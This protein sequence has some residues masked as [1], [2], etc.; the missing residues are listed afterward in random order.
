MTEEPWDSIAGALSAR[1][2]RPFEPSSVRA[3]GG[4]CI[5]EA[6]VLSDGAWQVFVKTNAASQFSMFEAEM[7]GLEL[8]ANANVIHVPEIYGGGVLGDRAW[9]GMEFIEMGSGGVSGQAEL[10]RCLARLHKIPGDRFG[11]DRD[12]TIGSTPQRNP[13]SDD[14]VAFYRDERLGFQFALAEQNGQRFDGA[15]RLLERLPR[16]FEGYTPVPALLHGD[17]WSGNVGFTV[18]GEPVIFDPAVYY[19]DREA[20][21]GIIEMFGGFSQAFYDAYRKEY[22][23]DAGFDRRKDLYLLYHQL[24]HF[25]LF[26]ASYGS[27]VRGTLRRLLGT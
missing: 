9:V 1:V 18:D 17:L 20:E 7:S 13:W 23:L 12:N 4:G 22:P 3:I 10:G 16:W 27:A 25:N 24:N 21:F 8:L 14:W 6:V 11:W 26:G 5:N 19:G 2:G 15:D